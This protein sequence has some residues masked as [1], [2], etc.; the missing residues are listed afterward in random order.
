[1]S[2]TIF[3]V[4]AMPWLFAVGA[5]L[6]A[7]AMLALLRTL[8]DSGQPDPDAPIEAKL[9]VDFTAIEEPRDFTDRT[10]Q[11]FDRM[12]AETDLGL[13]RGTALGWMAL[14]GLMVGGGVFLGTDDAFLG[15]IGLAGGVC[16]TLAV[17]ATARAYYRRQLQ[18]QL[19]EAFFLMARSLRAGLNLE[20]AID[21]AGKQGVEPLAKEFRRCSEHLRLGLPLP[22]AL[23]LT[24]TRVRLLDFNIFTSFATLYRRIGGSMPAL[25]DRL[26]STTRDRNQFRG[27]VRA[28][29]ALGRLSG[30]FVACAAPAIFIGYAVWQPEYIRL[31]FTVPGGMTALGVALVLEVVGLIWLLRL[32]RVDH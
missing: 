6:A 7:F 25:M 3:P 13:T 19:P 21:L 2:Q 17:I 28:T 5:G 16:A 27:Q 29:T 22:E 18:D 30:L 32:F 31:F 26:A 1:M 15:A 12:V 14:V 10:D 23:R 11:A 4:E 24:A 8:W 20:Q 9:G